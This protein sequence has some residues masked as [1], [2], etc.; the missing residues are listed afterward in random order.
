MFK[1]ARFYLFILAATPSR[2]LDPD[3]GGWAQAFASERGESTESLGHQGYLRILHIA[4]M[5]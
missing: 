5:E 3:Q 4:M 2:I 1:H